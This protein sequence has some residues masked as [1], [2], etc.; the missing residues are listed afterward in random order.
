M[1][2]FSKQ[3]WTLPLLM[4]HQHGVS[5]AF[6]TNSLLSTSPLSSNQRY[7]IN[8]NQ[9][10]NTYSSSRTNLNVSLDAP[11]DIVPPKK[12]KPLPKNMVVVH[13]GRQSM[14]FRQGSPLV[15]SGAISSSFRIHT[16]DNDD[17]DNLEEERLELGTL[18][19]V[20]V[21]SKNNNQRSG[22]R[23]NRNNRRNGKN[24]GKSVET[25]Y[26]HSNYFLDSNGVLVLDENSTSESI[27]SL[28]LIGYGVY[29][30]HSMYRVRILCHETSHPSTFKSIK[31]ILS[32]SSTQEPN[33]AIR[34]ILKVKFE[35]AIRSRTSLGL[36]NLSTDSYRLV[37]GEGDGLSG[38]AVDVL[39]G[40][41][42]VIMSSASWC[43]IYK[44]DIM[45]ILNQILNENDRKLDLIWRTTPSR[46]AQDGYNKDLLLQDEDLHDSERGILATES[47]IQ[48]KVFPWAQGQKTG[49]YCDQREN[50]VLVAQLCHNKRVLDLCCYNGGFALNAMKHGA[51]SCIGVDSSQDAID[52]ATEN[53]KIN[54]LSDDCSFVRDDIANYMKQTHEDGDTSYDVIILD[55]PKLAPSVSGLE[56]ASRKYHALNRDAM[57]LI[58]PIKGGILLTCTCSG[59]MT[60]KD[61]GQFFLQTVKA[62]SLSARRQITLLKTS[63]AASCHTQCPASFPAGAYLT[64]ALFHVSPL[65]R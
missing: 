46:L 64:A 28:Q 20:A 56:R 27:S 15:F 26:S 6:T 18:V 32:T 59:A 39:G 36:P 45:D 3:F 44:S 49:F 25:A 62:A 55:P 11:K 2:T 48:Y 52:T 10:T 47:D 33:E 9:P 61:G 1:R 31:Q 7:K 4:I 41:V 50:R 63:G 22:N 40:T 42:A 60:Q 43:E 19:A 12:Q 5:F 34:L 65:E 8:K 57:K 38:L 37:N 13:R 17:D 23:N 35:E 16:D 53:A 51:A 29:N 24:Q 54:G 21:S 14:A 58:D 30:P